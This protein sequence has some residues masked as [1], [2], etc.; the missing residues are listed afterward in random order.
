RRAA[1]TTARD[2][3]DADPP[4]APETARRAGR[5]G[6]MAS[7]HDDWRDRAGLYAL[8][9]LDRAERAAFEAHL[10]SCAVCA[11]ELRSLA[12]VTAALAYSV[13]Q[14]DPRPEL[15][16]RILDSL[17]ASDSSLASDFSRTTSL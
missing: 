12:L 1:R 11:A 14:T 4:R 2:G 13:P 5:H 16:A 10:A 9:A 8:D 7:E 6:V 17:V 15:R 3:E